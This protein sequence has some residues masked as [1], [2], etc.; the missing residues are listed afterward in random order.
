MLEHQVNKYVDVKSF[1]EVS[2]K[3]SNI[4]NLKDLWNANGTA[5]E[6]F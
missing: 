4:I 5:V 3:Q 6:M 2:A 1:S